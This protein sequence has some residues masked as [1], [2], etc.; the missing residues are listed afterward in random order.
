MDETKKLGM[1]CTANFVQLVDRMFDCL[2]VGNY[3]DGKRSRN[4]FKQP[5]RAAGDFRLKVCTCALYMYAFKCTVY[6]VQRTC[7]N[8]I[9]V[10]YLSVARNGLS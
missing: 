8:K 3:T 9:H 2:N 6:M 5:Y 4:C 1:V 10:Y 7:T